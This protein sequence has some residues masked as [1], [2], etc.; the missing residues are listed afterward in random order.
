[1]SAKERS[2]GFFALWTVVK[3]DPQVY[4]RLALAVVATK[5][6]FVGWHMACCTT[7]MPSCKNTTVKFLRC[8]GNLTWLALTFS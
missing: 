6:N 4:R 2:K 8:N 1:M 7:P 5:V 3:I